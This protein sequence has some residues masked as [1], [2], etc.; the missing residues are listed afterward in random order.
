MRI[1]FVVDKYYINSLSKIGQVVYKFL[2]FSIPN[3]KNIDPINNVMLSVLASSAVDRG[4]E[5]RS[6]KQMAIKYAALRNKS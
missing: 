2:I 6:V 4:Y 1:F 3:A 5:P